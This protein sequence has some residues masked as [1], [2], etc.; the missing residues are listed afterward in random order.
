MRDEQPL[1]AQPAMPAGHRYDEPLTVVSQ[2]DGSAVLVG[3]QPGAA[4]GTPVVVLRLQSPLLD[5]VNAVYL[6]PDQARQVAD[7][8]DCA[9]TAAA[10]A[11]RLRQPAAEDDAGAAG[12]AGSPADSASPSAA[13]GETTVLH[14]VMA[15]ERVTTD[16]LRAALGHLP[17]TARLTDFAAD[18]EIVL[19]FTST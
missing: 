14:T 1:T 8:L 6:P 13:Q 7:A 19:I 17:P 16:E 10:T 2:L 5:L 3:T 11:R 12:D 18:S 4:I 9:A 15:T